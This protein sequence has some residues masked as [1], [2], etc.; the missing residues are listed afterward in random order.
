[1]TFRYLPGPRDATTR[2]RRGAFETPHGR[3]ETPVFMPVGTRASVT[4]MTPEDLHGLG[5]EIILGNTYHLLLR[6]GPEAM[7]RFGGIH[8]FQGRAR[9]VMNNPGGYEIFSIWHNRASTEEGS[10]FKNYFGWHL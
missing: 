2:A 10:H 3:V 9:P 5:A 7:E 1:M 4:G 8:L 6:P